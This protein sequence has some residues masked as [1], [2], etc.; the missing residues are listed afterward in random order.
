VSRPARR[1]RFD[2]SSLPTWGEL[3]RRNKAL[4]DELRSLAHWIEND[5]QELGRYAA[6][7]PV[8]SNL[9]S[10]AASARELLRSM[11]ADRG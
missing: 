10:R 3:N 4:T 8:K 6:L 2:P 11:G 1:P 5:I 7:G 9:A